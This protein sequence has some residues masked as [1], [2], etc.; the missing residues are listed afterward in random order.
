[1][2]EGHPPEVWIFIIDDAPDKPH[3]KC[4]KH[5]H[6]VLVDD[7]QET[8]GQ[9]RQDNDGPVPLFTEITH[10]RKKNRPEEKFLSRRQDENIKDEE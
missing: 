2:R 1:M 6:G 5:H 10:L 7:V 8:E 3:K 4:N 9:G